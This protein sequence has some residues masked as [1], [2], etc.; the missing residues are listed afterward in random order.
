MKALLGLFLALMSSMSLAAQQEG[1]GTEWRILGPAFSHHARSTGQDVPISKPAHGVWDCHREGATGR[2][3][4]GRVVPAEQAWSG[5]NP[6]IGVEFSA[7]SS[8]GSSSRD[9][10]YSSLVRDSYGKIGVMAGAGRTWSVLQLGSVEIDLGIASGL[11]YRTVAAG[12]VN[13]GKINYCFENDKD[14]GNRCFPGTD[15]YQETVLKRRLVPFLLPMISM[16]EASSGLGV[17]I[18]F[19]PKIK[20]GRYYSV[21][22]STV[23]MQVTYKF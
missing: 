3:C 19:M 12:V 5:N 10:V 13:G 4:Y 7:P 14:F 18:S 16:T 9:L 1:R 23:M 11:W 22:T 8:P 17:N 21:P 6:A 15:D 20:L 2:S